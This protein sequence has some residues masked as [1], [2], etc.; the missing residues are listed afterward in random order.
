ICRTLRRALFVQIICSVV[1]VRAILRKTFHRNFTSNTLLIHYFAQFMQCIFLNVAP[2]P[3][4]RIF[5]CVVGAFTNTQVHI[6]MTPRP[7]TTICGSHKMLL[8]ACNRTG[9]TLYRSPATTPS[10]QMIGAVTNS[11]TYSI[12]H[13]HSSPTHL[14]F[15]D[16]TSMIED[17]HITGYVTCQEAEH[18]TSHLRN[19]KANLCKRIGL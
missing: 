10:V 13:K 5:S 19:L 8:R 11:A 9:Y 7:E 12:I 16:R 17:P 6:Y 14:L 15:T 4:T 2:Q 18:L 3:H 1:I